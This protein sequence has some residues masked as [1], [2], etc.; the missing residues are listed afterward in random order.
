MRSLLALALALPSCQ[1]GDESSAQ[2]VA[3]VSSAAEAS[4]FA[5]SARLTHLD[6]ELKRAR[7][8]WQAQPE[9]NE[10]AASLKE[11]ADVQLCQAASSALAQLT[12]VQGTR[13][14]SD[15]PV[16]AEGALALTR[17][18][19]RLRY[20]S[21]EELS[22]RRPAGDGGAPH[23]AIAGSARMPSLPRGKVA[24]SHDEQR[25]FEL[26]DGPVARLMSTT[27][28]LERDAVRNLGAYLEY[29]ELPVRRA[30]F[31]TVKRLRNEHP[32]WPALDRLLREATLLEADPD[33]KRELREFAASGLPERSHPSLHSTDS[34]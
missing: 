27:I 10:C 14:A 12:R 1:R 16:V 33:L 23:P 30:A 18:S 26:S 34:K 17:L 25:A 19:Q 29:A 6:A 20:L 3:S 5:S 21:L 11:K 4:S 2:A 7:E 9:L 22:A 28:H 15:L 32:Q 31:E 13:D 24:A 8:R